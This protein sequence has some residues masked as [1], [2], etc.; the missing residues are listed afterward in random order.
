MTDCR[1][2][3]PRA[4][5]G[6]AGQNPCI[7]GPG[8]TVPTLPPR[9]AKQCAF[10]CFAH[11]GR[12][13]KFARPDLPWNRK[14]APCTSPTRR[15]L[16]SRQ[17][18]HRHPGDRTPV[19]RR[20]R[21]ARPALNASGGRSA[22]VS[23]PRTFAP[24]CTC[25]RRTA[26]A[27]VRPSLRPPVHHVQP[28]RQPG[29]ARALPR[30]HLSGRPSRTLRTPGHARSGDARAGVR[31]R[32][33]AS[34][35]SAADARAPVTRRPGRVHRPAAAGIQPASGNPR[36]LDG[37]AR[38]ARAGSGTH[39]RRPPAHPLSAAQPPPGSIRRARVRPPPSVFIATP[40]GRISTRR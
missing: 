25:C 34:V 40:G 38:R 22:P 27:I 32:R 19:A 36:H 33:T 1:A 28:A 30:P 18:C 23:A 8:K 5:T 20:T 37:P 4:I 39:G 26:T 31:R 3:Q 13:R 7:T 15:Q 2:G 14:R 11:C 29:P 6:T 24:D 16:A 12:P 35:R 9:A 10:S 21:P 17:P